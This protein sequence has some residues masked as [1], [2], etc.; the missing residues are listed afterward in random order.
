MPAQKNEG[1]RSD[2]AARTHTDE[3][4]RIASSGTV[5]T[6]APPAE[7]PKPREA[8]RIGKAHAKAEDPALKR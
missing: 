6:D 1:E 5:A 7:T 8:A 2:T 4:H 3:Q